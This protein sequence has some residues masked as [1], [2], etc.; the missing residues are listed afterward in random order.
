MTRS[1]SPT[2]A[3]SLQVSHMSMP[4][5]GE[6]AN[7][8]RVVVRQED[9]GRTLLGVIDAL[10]HG[11]GAEEVALSAVEQLSRASLDAPLRTI[12]EDVHRALNGTRGAAA[13][14]CLIVGDRLEA[15]GVGNVDMRCN[16]TDIPFIYSA[17]ILGVRVPRFRVCD[18]RLA[19][20][21]RLVLF[22]DGVE[23]V[24]RL[25]DLRKLAPAD[26]CRTILN[27]HRRMEDDATVLIADLG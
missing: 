21:S 26:A 17:G 5:A 14:V 2:R 27:K 25:E 10:G 1:H 24:G 19:R 8:D 15:C 4:K 12:I 3:L 6:R 7:G 23:P 11:P 20:P 22:T 9:G 16:E 13:T 18:A